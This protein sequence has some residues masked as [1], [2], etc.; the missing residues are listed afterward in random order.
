MHGSGFIPFPDLLPRIALPIE[1]KTSIGNTRM[2]N[3]QF[4]LMERHQ[5][6][7]ELIRRAQSRRFPDPFEIVR[8]KKLKLAVKDRLA[9][10]IRK[11]SAT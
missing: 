4:R 2:S 11:N 3:I 6:L 7:D 5:R 8:L 10:L 9:R 1:C